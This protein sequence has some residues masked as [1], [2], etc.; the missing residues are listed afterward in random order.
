MTHSSARA[1]VFDPVSLGALDLDNRTVVAPMTRS[2]SIA[3]AIP[4][5]SAPLYY[6][7]R[8]GAG[9]I[10]SEGTCISPTAAGAQDVPGI[11]SDAQVAAWSTVTEAVHEA[12]GTIVCQLWHI[13]RAGLP[14]LL[15]DGRPPVGPSAVK[16]DGTTY[17]A[18]RFVPFVEPRELAA[19]EIAK[20]VRDYAAAAEN[21]RRAGFDGVE[22]HGANG[23]LIDQFL[24]ASA[25]RRTD[26]YGG[27]IENRC[28][29]LGEVA[30]AVAAAWDP[31]R[32]GVRLSPTS[33]FQD[34]HDPDPEGLFEAAVR[35]LDPLDLAYI[36]VVEPG[37]SGA[38]STGEDRR[39]MVGGAWVSARSRHR[40]ISTGDHTAE[41]ALAALRGGEV[42]AVGFGRPFLANPDLPERLAAGAELNEPVRETFYGGGD[43]GYLDYPSLEAE[44][45]LAALR[46]QLAEDGEAEL[47]RAAPL[48]AGTAPAE[49]PLAWA[50]DRLR[51]ERE[52]AAVE[53]A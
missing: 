51:E 15:P 28:R 30:E 41:S 19:D 40:V 47:P 17:L 12:G 24:Q 44:E 42:D 11:W 52:P 6:A 37:I 23:Y 49:W 16:I 18:Q 13:G 35:R 22:L 39:G 32:L 34:M 27:S 46:R 4:P 33:K 3:G 14:D 48:G 7:Q 2:R 9:L 25:N 29:F 20:I 45:T 10:V 53:P 1:T 26:G 38:A 36:H 43:E 50:L 5:A 21:A 8:A 31:R